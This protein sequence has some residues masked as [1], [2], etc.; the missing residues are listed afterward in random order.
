MI[1]VLEEHI[2]SYKQSKRSLARTDSIRRVN[3]GKNHGRVTPFKDLKKKANHWGSASSTQNIGE[4]RSLDQIRSLSQ[5]NV[6][7]KNEPNID[8]SV[9]GIEE[10]E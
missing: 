5:S 10:S 3:H 1:K 6:V 9:S 4:L 7:K 2:Q 8:R